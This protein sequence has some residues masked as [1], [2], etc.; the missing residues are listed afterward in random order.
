MA[1]RIAV[2]LKLLARDDRDVFAHY[3]LGM[4][5]FSAGRHD[6]AIGEFLRCIELDQKYVSAYVE[7]GKCLRAAGRLEEA[8]AML[9]RAMELAG[10]LGQSHTQDYIRGQLEG[11]PT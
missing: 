3:S 4:E 5:Y 10:Q 7:A 6:E 1:D 9:N 11:L 8:R 2:L